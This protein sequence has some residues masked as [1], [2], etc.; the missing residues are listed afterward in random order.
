MRCKKETH[1]STEREDITQQI[2][3]NRNAVYALFRSFVESNNRIRSDNFNTL[4]K[5]LK[6]ASACILTG[7]IDENDLC[8]HS[9]EQ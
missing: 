4:R 9:K 1:F 8:L 6:R 7:G 2:E 5:W 3:S